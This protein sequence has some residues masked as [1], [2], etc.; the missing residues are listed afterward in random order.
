MG[1]ILFAWLYVEWDY[2]LWVPIFLHSLMNLSWHIFEM[3]ET[4]LGGA[5]PNILRGLT[6]F[7]AIVLTIIY[8]KRQNQEL[9]ITFKQLIKKKQAFPNTCF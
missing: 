7:L 8:K 1:A 2:N 5:I 6:I 3:D 9:A 4:A